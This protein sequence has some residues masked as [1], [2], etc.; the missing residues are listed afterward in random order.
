[1]QLKEMYMLISNANIKAVPK[2]PNLIKNFLIDNGYLVESIDQNED[3]ILLTFKGLKADKVVRLS[4]I[5]EKNGFDIVS[6]SAKDNTGNGNF[7]VE[8]QIR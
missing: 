7:F 4:Y 3:R 2:D 6:F 1:M 5:L 8:V